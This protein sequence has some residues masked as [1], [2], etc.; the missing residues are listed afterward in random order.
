[1]DRRRGLT[2]LELLVAITIIGLITTAAAALLST[3]LQAHLYASNK[4]TLY[5]D[6]LIAME[7]MTSGV[8][9]STFLL[10][11]NNHAPSRDILAFSGTVNDDND[12]YFGDSL[13][14]RI[15]EDLDRDMNR[16]G[17]PGISGIDDDGDGSPDETGNAWDDDEDGLTNEDPLD[18]VDNDGDGNID[19]D[20]GWDANGDAKNGIA[21]MDDDGDGSVDEGANDRDDDEDGL[22]QE[23]SLNPIVYFLDSGTNTL[24]ETSP[25]GTT[26]DLAK[27]VTA[28]T[29][30]YE[31]PDATRDPRISISLTLTGDDGESVTFF[32]Y[33]YPRN[34][35]QKSGKRVR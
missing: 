10:I 17:D 26:A 34:V 4:S 23:D 18:G 32:E 21:G 3:S 35:V 2:L 1:M 6:G 13:F 7:R 25:T 15:D 30:T 14:P 19:E 31:P 20:V 28:F 33:V 24:K 12:F 27:N 9:K 16:D 5:R 29:V 22:T 11:P 8:K